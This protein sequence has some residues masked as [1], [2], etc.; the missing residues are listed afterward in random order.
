MPNSDFVGKKITLQQVRYSAMHPN[1]S[2]T[3]STHHSLS[4]W[5]L[6]KLGAMTC[7]L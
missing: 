4:R 3:L 1:M 7:K 5:L 6:G 2:F